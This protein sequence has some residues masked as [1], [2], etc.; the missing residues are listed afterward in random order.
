MYTPQ[1]LNTA[2]PVLKLEDGTILVGEFQ[3]TIGTQMIF[4]G[5]YAFH[6]YQSCSILSHHNDTINNVQKI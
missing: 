5:I 6:H 1:G 3:E 4:Q 2:N